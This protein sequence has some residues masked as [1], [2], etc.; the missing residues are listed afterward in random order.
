M[1]SAAVAT[2]ATSRTSP[3]T[4]TTWGVDEPARRGA[5]GAVGRLPTQGHPG[6]GRRTAPV[7]AGLVDVLGASGCNQGT[8]LRLRQSL[9]RQGNRRG[10][11]DFRSRFV[12]GKFAAE[13]V[14]FKS[15]GPPP[16]PA[17]GGPSGCWPSPDPAADLP[18]AWPA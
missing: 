2:T 13:P 4:S 11:R 17:G 18:S 5:F 12:P 7:A 1:P 15:D 6:R 9:L 14:T 3:N 8:A 10:T 16:N